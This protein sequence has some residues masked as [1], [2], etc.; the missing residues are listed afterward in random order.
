M[1]IMQAGVNREV[2]STVHKYGV[3]RLLQEVLE[4]LA[5]KDSMPRHLRC[6]DLNY[7]VTINN[8]LHLLICYPRKYTAN[9]D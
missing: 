3:D 7:L 8:I 2:K 9:L 4:Y 5:L 6:N 1:E